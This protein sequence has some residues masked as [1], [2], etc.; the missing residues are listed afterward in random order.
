MPQCAATAEIN[1]NIMYGARRLQSTSPCGCTLQ[2]RQ[3][4][5]PVQATFMYLHV[6]ELDGTNH[7]G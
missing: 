3:W 6:G 7:Q 2:G 1:N 4:W 5:P